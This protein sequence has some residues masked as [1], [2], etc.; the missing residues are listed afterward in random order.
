MSEPLDYSS[1]RTAPSGWRMP[2]LL[3]G[4]LESGYF[5][6]F[7]GMSISAAQWL[8]PDP[9]GIRAAMTWLPLVVAVIIVLALIPTAT[10]GLV[11]WFFQRYL[12]RQMRKFGPLSAILLG[13]VHAVVCCVLG[14]ILH[15]GDEPTAGILRLF[16]LTFFVPASVAFFFTRRHGCPDFRHWR[17]SRAALR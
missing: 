12:R 15:W 13:I 7:A 9:D 17:P 14:V 5:L 11:I 8:P 1:V 3:M 2:G 4:C 6:G 10:F 16:F